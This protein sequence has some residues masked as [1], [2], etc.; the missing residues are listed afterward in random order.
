MTDSLDD[1]AAFLMHRT[2]DADLTESERLSIYVLVDAY[3]END[4][5]P[6]VAAALRVAADRFHGHRDY[7]PEWAVRDGDEA[8]SVVS[9]AA[10]GGDCPSPHGS[11]PAHKGR[12][13]VRRHRWG[14]RGIPHPG[15]GGLGRRV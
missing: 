12:S 8:I 7:R 13:R 4:D 2:A 3:Q 6:K 14:T 1:L 10:T 15:S 5:P 9:A 11:I